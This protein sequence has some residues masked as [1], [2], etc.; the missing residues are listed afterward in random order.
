MVYEQISSYATLINGG[1]GSPARSDLQE[2]RREMTSAWTGS[3]HGDVGSA[4]RLIVKDHAEVPRVWGRRHCNACDLQVHDPHWTTAAREQRLTPRLA[5]LHHKLATLHHKLATL[6]HKLATLHHKLATLHHKLA[7]LHH[8]LA[9]LHH[10][11]ATKEVITHVVMTPSLQ[12]VPGQTM[13]PHC[14]QVVIT[15]TQHEN[16]LMAWAICGG[17]A[18]F[19]CFLCCCIPFC[20]DSC[21]DVMHVCPNCNKVIYLYKRL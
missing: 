12:D 6:H 11:L 2:S 5:T 4:T 9:T 15:R 7:T 20:I 19:G 14:Q 1:P 8:K 3:H 10:K 17:L 16:G 18:I 21:K 13:C